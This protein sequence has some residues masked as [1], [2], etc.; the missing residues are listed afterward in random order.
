MYKVVVTDH[1][2][3]DLRQEERLVADAGGVVE[4]HQCTT[5]DEVIR[6]A[7][8]ADAVLTQWAPM[9]R[10]VVERLDRCKAIVRYGIG[11]D[12]VD[13]EAAGRKGI[14]VANIPDYALDE[15]ADHTMALLLTSMRKIPQVMRQIQAGVWETNPCR[16]MRSLKA[17]VLGLAGFGNIARKVATRAQAF[18]MNVTAYDPYVDH[19][20]Y[21]QFGVA[22]VSFETLLRDSD[23]ISI[24]L[25]LTAETRHL[26]NQ[27][28]LARMKKG[29]VIV[30]TSRGGI[31]H[32]EALIAALQS[33]TLAGAGLDVL[34]E[35]PVLPDSALLKLPSVT[36]TSHCAWYT[37]EALLRLQ[38]HAA[39]EVARALTGQAMKHVV[40]KR[41]LEGEK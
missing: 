22:P 5:P 4:V 38:L 3:P 35:E 16:P 33:G 19:A 37:E 11:V 40:N 36:L 20:V 27:E 26:I 12:N 1:G 30:N 9:T 13:L 31:V 8:Q 2:F 17:S 14:A 32:T 39:H 7:S 21:E 15:V 23:A 24:H 25:P 29:A 28:T 10:E 6:A 18:G 41:W 34:E